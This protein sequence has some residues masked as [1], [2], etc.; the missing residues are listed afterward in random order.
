MKLLKS[1]NDPSQ[2]SF[3]K[4]LQA[5]L[6]LFRENSSISD[7]TFSNYHLAR[8][9]Y[10][11]SRT[12]EHYGK[13]KFEPAPLLNL[14]LLDIGCGKTPLGEDLALRGANVTAIDINPETIKQAEDTAHQHGTP[15]KFQTSTPEDMI[16]DDKKYDVILCLD[17]LEFVPN[18]D[19]FLWAVA[20]LLNPGGLLLFSCNN[21]SL[22]SIFWNIIMAEKL[23]KWVPKGYFPYKNFRTPARMK[24]L[25][26]SHNLNVVDICGLKFDVVNKRWM[27]TC[28]PNIRYI[29]TATP[30]KKNNF[31]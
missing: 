14:E 29:G 8:R 23:L 17:V 27:K 20:Q 6:G 1:D 15:I 12:C 2:P 31:S 21:K 18:P 11:L 30:S 28:K 19:R 22:R 10:I 13:D 9:K 5:F 3:L 26:A 24:K 25:L 7:Q 4:R 16:R